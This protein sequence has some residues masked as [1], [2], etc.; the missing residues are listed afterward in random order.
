L[1]HLSG[2]SDDIISPYILLIQDLD[3]TQRQVSYYPRGAL[4]KIPYAQYVNDNTKT[5]GWADVKDATHCR[6]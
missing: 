1:R 4:G 6:L 3:G 5:K 2:W